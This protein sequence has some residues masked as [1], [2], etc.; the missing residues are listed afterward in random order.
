MR[1]ATFLL[2]SLAMADTTYGALRRTVADRDDNL[3]PALL[4]AARLKPTQ[5]S[6]K[7]RFAERLLED[8]RSSQR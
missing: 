8:R 7:L 6:Q 3:S 4:P 1:A 5:V 2:K